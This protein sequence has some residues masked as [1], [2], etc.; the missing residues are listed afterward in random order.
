FKNRAEIVIA[1]GGNLPLPQHSVAATLGCAIDAVS[2][3]VGMIRAISRFYATPCF[4]AGAGPDYVN[5]ALIV[6]YHASVAELLTTL[7]RIEADFGRERA[8]RWGARTLDLDVIAAGQQ[9]SPDRATQA[10]WINLPPEAR[11]EKTP[12]SA[13]VPHPRLQERAFVLVPMLDIC[14]DWVHPVT[15][16]TVAQMAAALAPGEIDAVRPI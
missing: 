16:R 8:A 1:L 12:T 6:E 11:G 3:Q 14:P 7:H 9:I 15:R 13:I 10:A 4:P 5:A 2:R